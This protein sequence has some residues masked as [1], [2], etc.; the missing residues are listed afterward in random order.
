[1]LEIN[2]HI[3]NKAIAELPQLVPDVSLWDKIETKLDAENNFTY[4]KNNKLQA[5]ITQLPVRNPDANLWNRIE[6]K[7]EKENPVEPG[8]ENLIGAI[9]EL[10]QHKPSIN[11]WNIIEKSLEQTQAKV[12]SIKRF[13][14]PISIAASILLLV[15]LYWFYSPSNFATNE[16]IATV[17]SEE[18]IQNTAASVIPSGNEQ[19]DNEIMEM[20]KIHC[21]SIPESCENPYFNGLLSQYKELKASQEELQSKAT[22]NNDDSFLKKSIIKIEKE[23]TKVTK[24]LVE[25]LIS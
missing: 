23:K 21:N 2:K 12:F 16:H 8:R 6:K 7:L 22:E 20:I 4:L 3:L 15:G 5:A 10:P 19:N 17:A 13:F 24:K 11:T 25:Y 18:I 1:M 14:Y 9:R